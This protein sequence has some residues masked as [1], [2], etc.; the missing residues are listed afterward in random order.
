MQKIIS[1]LVNITPKEIYLQRVNS[2]YD[3]IR[4]NN[5]GQDYIPLQFGGLFGQKAILDQSLVMEITQFE[6]R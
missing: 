6:V 4:Q 3:K 5:S 1:K 2:I